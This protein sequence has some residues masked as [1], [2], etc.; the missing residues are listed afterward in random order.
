VVS[1]LS[2]ICGSPL[3]ITSVQAAASAFYARKL[4]DDILGFAAA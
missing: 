4:D 2:K 3:A 1:L